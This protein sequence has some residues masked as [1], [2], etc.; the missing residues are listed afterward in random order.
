MLRTLPITIKNIDLENS[1]MRA[2]KTVYTWQERAEQRYRLA[3]LDAHM[4]NDI[5]LSTT[6]V[7]RET[8]KRF[9][10]A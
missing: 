5:G 7:A 9:W 3:L 1:L 6:D 2:L 10:Q 8:D 4:L